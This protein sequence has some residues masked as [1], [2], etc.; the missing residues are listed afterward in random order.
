[1]ALKLELVENYVIYSDTGTGLNVGE[2]AVNHCVYRET[3]T[4]FIIKEEIDGGT[5]RIT[6]A[7]LAANKWLD[8]NDTPYTE[9]TMRDFL[10]ANTGF[11]AA[12][13]GSGAT[14][15]ETL[16]FTETEL[17][18][19]NSSTPLILKDS[20]PIGQAYNLERMVMKLTAGTS[21]YATSAPTAIR[22]LLN[23]GGSVAASISTEIITARD[24]AICTVYPQG[25]ILTTIATV[26]TTTIPVGLT[27]NNIQLGFATTPTTV[28]GGN[29]VLTIDLYY[30]I[31][32][33]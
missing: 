4:E 22:L 31:E 25:S 11:K 26:G 29:G 5:A 3:A 27:G 30:T 1:M 15:K 18:S 17:L 6:K 9:E 23:G 2:Y 21:A 13:G 16:T 19:W 14:I 24:N 7:D 32:T 28:F 10:R 20:L 8:T 33:F 12:S